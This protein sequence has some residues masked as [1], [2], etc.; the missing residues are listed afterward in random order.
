MPDQ[1][2]LRSSLAC[3][4][5]AAGVVV[6]VGL[7]TPA[8]A[9]AQYVAPPISE[10]ATGERYAV[11]VGASLWNPGVEGALSSAQFGILGSDIDFVKDL[12]YQ[13]TTFRELR[14][15]LR[16]AKKHR[17]R[18]DYT[19]I[20]YVSEGVT[21]PRDVVFN[22]Q[23]FPLN[24]PISSE[25]AW[26]V[27]RFGYE[28]D[29]V[30]RNRGF[31]GVVLDGRY[32]QLTA[33]LSSPIDAEFTSAKAVLPAIGAVGRGYVAKNVAINFEVSGL[34]VPNTLL[35]TATSNCTLQSSCSSNY[36]DWNVGTT[37]NLTN[38]VGVQAGWRRMTTVLDVSRDAANFKIQ[39]LW[40]GAVV[41]Y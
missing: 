19:P 13:Q 30:Y 11:E 22:G 17:F 6:S 1:L 7:T 8:R 27:W 12:S 5:V 23:R 25:F 33:N 24:L 37:V 32:T 2:S 26:K 14:M 34:I 4:I 41:R 36:F 18:V 21:L 39:G 3:V 20:D 16:P 40:F 38:Y 35:K 10:V 31:V 9:L 28:Y 29:F 15:V